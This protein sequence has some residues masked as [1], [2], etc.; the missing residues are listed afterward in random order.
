M[1]ATPL[2]YSPSSPPASFPGAVPPVREYTYFYIFRLYSKKVG[3]IGLYQLPLPRL[4]FFALK[5]PAPA[6]PVSKTPYGGHK[7]LA[8]KEIPTLCR[9]HSGQSKSGNAAGA[10]L[11]LGLHSCVGLSPMTALLLYANMPEA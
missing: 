4:E 3:Y 11:A 6:L 1:N 8:P 7:G 2:R 9:P 5:P 10:A